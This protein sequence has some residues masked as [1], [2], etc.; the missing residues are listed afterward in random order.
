MQSF[1]KLWV[2]S[3][4]FFLKT[5]MCIIWS[6]QWCVTLCLLVYLFWVWHMAYMCKKCSTGLDIGISFERASGKICQFEIAHTVVSLNSFQILCAHFIGFPILGIKCTALWDLEWMRL[7]WRTINRY[8]GI[9]LF[10]C[11]RKPECPQKICQGGHG[12][13]KANSHTTTG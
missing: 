9:P 7:L 3:S 8:G 6:W 13:G 4:F 11:R 1:S 2:S 10:R 12:I 5:A